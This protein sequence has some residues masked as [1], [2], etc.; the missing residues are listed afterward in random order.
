[1]DGFTRVALGVCGGL[2]AATPLYLVMALLHAALGPTPFRAEIWLLGLWVCAGL[3]L[4]LRASALEATR[5]VLQ[6]TGAICIA[7]PLIRW[8]VSR[9]ATVGADPGGVDVSLLAIGLLALA[10][11]CALRRIAGTLWI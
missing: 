3:R 6:V 9:G 5:E 1:M 4:G 2:V 11:G 10:L 8:M 7:A